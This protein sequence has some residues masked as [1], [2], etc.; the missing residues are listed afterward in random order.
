VLEPW[1]DTV[2]PGRGR[3]DRDHLLDP[4]ALGGERCSSRQLDHQRRR[5]ER[6][7][8]RGDAAQVVGALRLVEAAPSGDDREQRRGGA[9]L[10]VERVEV[11][12][13]RRSV[14]HDAEGSG[15]STWCTRSLTRQAR[16]L[17][18]TP[19]AG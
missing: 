6:G 4:R 1:R 8:A 2:E 12:Q 11:R 10:V 9:N 7:T 14:G 18:S 16:G 15:S 5:S 13:R 19:R 17:A 3:D